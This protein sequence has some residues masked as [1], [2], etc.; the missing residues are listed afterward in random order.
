MWRESSESLK[1]MDLKPVFTI[2]STVTCSRVDN[3]GAEANNLAGHFRRSVYSRMFYW[4]RSSLRFGFGYGG[5]SARFLGS[6][7][8]SAGV[9]GLSQHDYCRG[10]LRRGSADAAVDQ[11]NSDL[12]ACLC[13]ADGSFI[14]EY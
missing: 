11:H 14:W 12:T 4:L 9:F 3:I 13:G 6:R 5:L 1:Y 10:L 8:F 7:F 2:R